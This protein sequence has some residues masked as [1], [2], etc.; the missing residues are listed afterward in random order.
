MTLSSSFLRQLQN[1]SLTSDNR[2]ELSCE[3]A[4]EFEEKGD[5]ETARE[6]MGEFWGGVG[7]HPNIEG[8]GPGRAAEVLLRAGTLTGW[9]G[10]CR[11]I[12]GAQESAKNLITESIRIFESQS[13][14]K[15][16][17][18]AQ[19]ELAYCYW[20]EGGYDEARIILE[21]VL[22][23][24][25]TDSELR[26]RAVLRL[27][28]VEWGAGRHELSLRILTDYASLFDKVNN[29]SIKGG[30]HNQLA[31]VFIG[32]A[33]SKNRADYLDR[34]FVEYAAASYHFEQAGHMHY[35]A[36]VENNLGYL[37][38]ESS[39]FTEA[40]EHLDSARRLTVR[41]KDVV[42]TARVD[43]TRARV[44]LAQGKIVKAE[45]TVR[46]AVC[47]FGGGGQ[48]GVLA[49]ALITHARI[50][51]QLKQYDQ[52]RTTFQRAID[53]ARESGAIHLAGQAALGMVEVLGAHSTPVR[54]LEREHPVLSDELKRYEAELI[55][56]ALRR[57]NGRVTRAAQLLGTTHQNLSHIL[58][59]R[60]RELRHERTPIVRRRRGLI[61]KQI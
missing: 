16:I 19:T 58:E 40:H 38:Y 53:I 35:R 6:V 2:A 9:I 60:H 33:E 31:V 55:R 21:G 59:H 7:E 25:T 1:P 26:A 45:K 61:K 50:L 54:V 47:A 10:S 29:H 13:Y 15:K 3:A 56:D 14:T 18:E 52:A 22:G 44:F 28:I 4:R 49:E 32:L 5:Y 57:A 24:L 41:L 48:Q 17:L 12:E 51:T 36:N 30:Y 34:S 42:H 20:R 39:K 23:K 46:S 37:F 8:L 11:Q 27:A 43:E